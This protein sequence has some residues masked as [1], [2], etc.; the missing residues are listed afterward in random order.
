[1]ADTLAQPI[2]TYTKSHWEDLEKDYLSPSDWKKI[3]TI[4]DFL[5]PFRRATL[6]T[7]GHD[8][9]ID[10]VL[11]TMDIIL[12]YL[13]NSLVSDFD[14]KFFLRK[15]TSYDRLNL[16]LIKTFVLGLKKH[17]K[18]LINIILKPIPL[19]YTLLL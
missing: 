3:R 8:A 7:Q 19:L 6:K 14:L 9:T 2:D 4:K 15:L 10:S 1:V 18:S 13:K 17:G 5:Q 12:K 11:F 16:L